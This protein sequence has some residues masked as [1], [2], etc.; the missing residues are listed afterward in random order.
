MWRPHAWASACLLLISCASL[1]GVASGHRLHS[2]TGKGSEEQLSRRR[3]RNLQYFVSGQNYAHTEAI[4]VFA[5][6]S[7]ANQLTQVGNVSAAQF[8]DQTFV[9]KTNLSGPQTV[10]IA[11]GHPNSV[12]AS[13]IQPP[14]VAD[15]ESTWLNVASRNFTVPL[16]RDESYLLAILNPNSQPITATI[17]IEVSTADNLECADFREQVGQEV[18]RTS[19]FQELSV[20]SYLGKQSVVSYMGFTGITCIAYGLA[21][22]T[23]PQ[24]NTN[25]LQLDVDI[26]S[27]NIPSPIP[28]G[29]N[30]SMFVI[31]AADLINWGTSS[32]P[33]FDNYNTGNVC[34][35][36][37]TNPGPCFA[38]ADNLDPKETYTI[39][40][41]QGG[42]YRDLNAD[43]QAPQY[44]TLQAASALHNNSCAEIWPVTPP[45]VP[46]PISAPAIA[47]EAIVG[48]IVGGV[49]GAGIIVL[50]AGLLWRRHNN[51][52]T[53]GQQPLITHT[54][55]SYYSQ[56]TARDSTDWRSKSLDFLGIEKEFGLSGGNLPPP[57][58]DAQSQGI[59]SIAEDGADDQDDAQSTY[60]QLEETWIVKPEDLHCKMSNGQPVLLGTGGFGS[61]YLGVLNRVR[62]VAVKVVSSHSKK[63]QQRFIREIKT[64]KACLDP[65]IVQ[66]LGVCVQGHQILMVMQYMPGG[67]LWG[68]LEHDSE[69]EYHWGRSICMDVAKGLVFL[70]SKKIAHLDLKT[71]NILLSNNDEAKISDVG[72]GKLIQG[73]CTTATQQGSFYWAS[74]EQ[75]LGNPT[76]T[77][78]DMF[79][80]GTVLWEICTGEQP[81]QRL[82]RQLRVPEEA[83]QA[84]ADL[85]Q[86]ALQ[87]TSNLLF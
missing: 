45:P 44:W 33:N 11:N 53:K 56:S 62:E 81:R 6:D 58:H 46:P 52:H 20:Y 68:K 2:F 87:N 7:S 61:V 29:L 38:V 86:R 15:G 80:M 1:L 85:I 70:H 25:D 41:G 18:N 84:I 79:S 39:W 16:E 77:M 28:D 83:P 43:G 19:T 30:T 4:P 10:V 14:N 9:S 36:T 82:L 55:A 64:L 49:V 13:L 50:L 60:S 72:L 63:Q 37:P 47:P 23:G 35:I 48:G 32:F 69:G 8:Q 26:T 40:T 12:N 17:S 67:D 22:R 66:F 34:T 42:S 75:L 57:G 71:P 51:R 5:V 3:A 21:Y 65:N 74:P 54:G 78:S 24:A 31:S 76:S 27:T 73:P 59:Q